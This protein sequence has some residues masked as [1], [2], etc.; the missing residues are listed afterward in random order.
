MLSIYAESHELLVVG[1]ARNGDREAF[2]DLVRRREAWVRSLML[3][4]CGDP[5]LADDLA[6]Q[7]FMQ[8]WRKLDQLKQPQLFGAWLKRLAVNEWLQHLR[9]KDV[10]L[11]DE[12][13]EASVG[14]T[15]DPALA[16]DLESALAVL[17]PAPRLC[18]ILA[19]QEQMSHPEIASLTGVPLGTVKS[20][21]RRGAQTLREIL[22]AYGIEGKRDD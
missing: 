19:Y 20:H 13:W 2:Q 22:A 18:V 7:A 6:Q 11:A 17:P 9:K 10:P 4:S 15:T 16:R 1:L 21:I 3:R 12:S 8:A 14:N 5:T